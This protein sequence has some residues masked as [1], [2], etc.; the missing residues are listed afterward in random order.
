L[1]LSLNEQ[2]AASGERK[3]TRALFNA[4]II[5]VLVATLWPCD[6]FARNGVTWLHGIRG[7][8]F[9]NHGVVVS[10]EYLKPAETQTPES[11]SLEFL[12]RPA[13]WNAAPILAFY[14]GQPTCLIVGQSGERLIVTHDAAIQSDAP[15]EIDFY[16][17]HI[18]RPGKLA[19]VTIS[20]GPNGTA[21]YLDGK[22]ASFFPQWKLSR[23][24]LSGQIVLG[25]SPTMYE[26]WV[27]ELQGLAVYSKEL[28][29][30]DALR[31]YREWVDP[32]GPADNDGA[33]ARYRF[34]EAAGAE[35]R[36]DVAS[37]PNLE[38]PAIF[39][40]PHKALL[41]S[42]TKEFHPTR[43]YVMDVLV[44]IAGFAPLGLIACAYFSWTRSPWKAILMSTIA[45][46]SL[47]FVIETLQYYIP[48][49]FSG[50]TDIMTNTLG[51]AVGAAL[52]RADVV[53]HALEEIK[54][55]RVNQHE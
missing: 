34:V 32:S 41:R 27:G 45:C 26:P 1:V 52:I 44:N 35:V 12:V 7:V 13:N 49:R 18:F 50:T 53:R 14:H 10:N 51:A 28:T 48:R 38:I 11:Y 33:I 5:A 3:R 9:E 21:V 2:S 15:K 43:K 37:G 42:M 17:D 22:T 20:S 6:F 19:L 29:I 30:Q 25:T 39:A 40:V 46:G 55:I 4:A 23:S 8:K 31:H 16:A 54:L 24:D 47:S 36:D